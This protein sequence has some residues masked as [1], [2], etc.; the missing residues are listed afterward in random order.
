LGYGRRKLSTDLLVAGL[1]MSAVG[2]LGGWNPLAAALIYGAWATA[3]AGFL[4]LPTPRRALVATA[5][6]TPIVGVPILLALAAFEIATSRLHREEP[7]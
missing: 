2:W 3:I 7:R 1:L 6:A 4:L 5:S